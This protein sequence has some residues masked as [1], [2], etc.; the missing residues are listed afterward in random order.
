MQ[1]HSEPAALRNHNISENN[2]VCRKNIFQPELH[3][4]NALP[5]HDE[6]GQIAWPNTGSKTTTFPSMVYGP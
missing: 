3:Q 5:T 2:R 1:D 4:D 6:N